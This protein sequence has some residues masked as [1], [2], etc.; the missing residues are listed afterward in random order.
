MLES[1]D[2]TRRRLDPLLRILHSRLERDVASHPC[3]RCVGIIMDGNRRWASRYG[4]KPWMGHRLGKQKVRELLEW[5][6]P[7]GIRSLVLYAFSAENF[8]RSAEEVSEIMKL[9]KEG[10]DELASDPLLSSEAI[11][12]RVIGR[13]DLLPPPL[14]QSIRTVEDLSRENDSYHLTFAIA[15]SGRTELTDACRAIAREVHDGTLDSSSITESTI[16]SHLYAPDIPDPD[17]IIRTSGEQ[18]ISNFLTWQAVY[19]ELHFTP[20]LWPDFSYI[21]FLK[22][23]RSYQ[24]R[25][26]RIGR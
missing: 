1:M 12:V 24:N 25:E 10:F 22:A 15:Y 20:T 11:R 4:K 18:R 19:S 23:L 6:K 3:P 5:C 26:R 13:L 21:D 2:R 14:L 16:T 8:S 9:M 7:F 17:L